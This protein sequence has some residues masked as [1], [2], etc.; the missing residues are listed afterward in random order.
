MGEALVRFQE[1]NT[2]RILRVLPER[3]AVQYRYHVLALL[4]CLFYYNKTQSILSQDGG[5]KYESCVQELT[6]SFKK[7]QKK[8][9]KS[10]SKRQK[11]NLTIGRLDQ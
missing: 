11:Y 8:R 9:G 5:V 4:H 2:Y 6:L 1:D 7:E 10:S 3:T